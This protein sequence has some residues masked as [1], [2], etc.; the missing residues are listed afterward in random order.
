[1]A[2]GLPGGVFELLC[3]P[4][5]NPSRRG[6]VLLS[7]QEALSSRPPQAVRPPSPGLFGAQ[8]TPV[9]L[10]T[11][12]RAPASQ[13]E[14]QVWPGMLAPTPC[15]PNFSPAFPGRGGGDKAA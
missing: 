3:R 6:S 15:S 9:P 7:Q 2:P 11:G 12:S 4:P 10:P 13:L 14:S 5:L 1:M 8:L